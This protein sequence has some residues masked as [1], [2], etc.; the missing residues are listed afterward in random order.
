MDSDGNPLIDASLLVN[1][2]E[3]E[4]SEALAAAAAAKRAE[5]RAEQRALQRAI[6]RKRQE[7][8]AEQQREHEVE[9]ER[10]KKRG[11]GD[12]S[13][14]N[15][16]DGEGE[17]GSRVKFIPKKRR[18]GIT[19]TNGNSQTN[20]RKIISD[21]ENQLY[22]DTNTNSKRGG[23]N[24]VESNTRS[25]QGSIHHLSKSEI[26]AIK[27]TYLGESAVHD[28]ASLRKKEL[29][30]QKRKK[31]KKKTIFKFEWDATDDTT[32]SDDVLPSMLP[33]VS[34]SSSTLRP[35][36]NMRRRDYNDDLSKSKAADWN[37][38]TKPL[39][40]MTSRD[41]RILR[42]NYDISVKGG[43]CPPPLR[44]F[45]DSSSSDMPSIHSSL[46]RAIERVLKYKEPSPIQRQAIPIGLQRRDLIGV[47]ETGSGKTAAFGIPL[48][49]HILT[50]PSTILSTVAENGPLALVMAPTRELAQQIEA[51]F[52]KL[53]SM[54]SNLKSTCI[55]GGQSIQ[56][57][58]M[59]LRN[60]VHIV[61]GTPGRLND[62]IENAYLVLNQCSYIVLDEA[63]RM[64][65]LGFSE[66]IEQVLDAMGG[67]LKSENAEEAYQQEAIDMKNLQV[68]VPKYRLT[69]MFSATMPPDVQ[70]M[71]KKYLRHP[72]VVSIGDG[73][74][75]GGKN[76]RIEQ[77]VL[78]LSSPAMK[79]KALRGVL[80]N[81]TS[82][83]KV[84][85]FVNEKKHCEGV[86]RMVE[87]FGRRCVVLHGGK[88]QDQ[89]EENLGLFKRGGVVL[90]ATDVAGRGLDIPNVKHVVNYD[91]PSRSIDNYCHRIGRTGR[92]GAH[93]F[94]TS[95]I[96]D[97]D[98]GIMA[99]LKAYLEST[100][101]AIPDRLARH[102][103]AAS[104][105]TIY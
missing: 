87:R 98:E 38:M 16:G 12:G 45:R 42:E 9:A 43:K 72:A 75:G 17:N 59:I 51:E 7:R 71:A 52:V 35:S 96:T 77:R 91:V 40:K 78:F 25:S 15:G 104:I 68:C 54:Q 94:A 47:A 5:E 67:A 8:L 22:R 105:K 84:M 61:V 48:C 58:A 97:E 29:E 100:N 82:N 19:R 93:G 26:N 55:V 74:A 10:L 2:S 65:D 4:R 92:A 81:T 21:G 49:H 18:V 53:L 41:W 70:R 27:K 89:R 3:S 63:D 95:F 76:Q 69:A 90:V 6:E 86:G 23:K 33:L 28:E 79:E 85:V 44:N 39:Q 102:P 24:K 60:G 88:S 32:N 13:G 11:L 80:N 14:V 56:N 30:K 103:A 66:Q 36:A 50:L 83:D 1:L 62:C 37:V 57:Q 20:V 73:A 99:P 46:I 64:I 101:A 34:S 31:Q